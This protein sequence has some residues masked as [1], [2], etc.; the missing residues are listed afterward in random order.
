MLIVLAFPS[1][2]CLF[3]CSSVCHLCMRTGS[4]SKF[5]F[6]SYYLLFTFS[7]TKANFCMFALLIA[8]K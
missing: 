6:L 4:S 1:D 5:M 2:S 8:Q 7:V 3:F